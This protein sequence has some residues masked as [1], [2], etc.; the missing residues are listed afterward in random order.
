MRF[1]RAH[2]LVIAS[3]LPLG[4]A[5][6]DPPPSF[7]V[8]G[9]DN[10]VMTKPPDAP[11]VIDFSEP[12][13]T[14][15]LRLKFVKSIVDSEG[16][17]LDEGASADADAFRETIHAAVDGAALE[18]EDRTYGATVD[19]GQ[20]R[21]TVDLDN[22]FAVSQPYLL[23][24]E[25]GL[26]DKDENKTVPR[27]RL[28]FSFNLT[29]GCPTALPT[30]YYYF[31]MNVDYLATQIQVFA[32][33]E[34]DPE[35]GTWRAIYTNGNR[36]EALNSRPGCPSCSG[37]TPVCALIPAP[38]CVKPS[39][40]QTALEQWP[41]FLPEWDPPNGYTFIADGFACDQESGDTA[42]GTFPFLIA[43]TIGTGNIDVKA[44]NTVVTG[45]FKT[46]AGR[47]HGTGSLSAE[48]VKL[49]GIGKDPTG[50]TWEAISL[51]A[52]EVKAVEA[53]GYE[54]PTDLGK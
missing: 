23:L 5:K 49:N 47:W 29:G 24:V 34:A 19:L 11:F 43:V 51:S 2:T 4:C 6:F 41:D 44:E 10:G 16:N 14:S 45:V 33:L 38:S 30:G 13:R 35:K 21:A 40:K 32:Y 31:L 26:E 3:L 7:E 12:I 28:P 22:A 8:E 50:G 17:L 36:R 53:F 1:T 9:L 52:D 46:E 20:R 18:D 27:M 42:F 48:R 37:D 39:Q 15:S 54:I 25:P